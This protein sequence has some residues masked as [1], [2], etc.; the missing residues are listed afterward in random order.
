MTNKSI[1]N[2]PLN[3]KRLVKRKLLLTCFLKRNCPCNDFLL[4]STK[5]HGSL[6]NSNFISELNSLIWAIVFD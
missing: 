6:L 1:S 2:M 4:S 3:P 5:P